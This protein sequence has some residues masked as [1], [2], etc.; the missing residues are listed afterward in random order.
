MG[1]ATK[2]PHVLLAGASGGGSGGTSGAGVILAV[3]AAVVRESG[4]LC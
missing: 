1:S 4:S 2:S 3:L